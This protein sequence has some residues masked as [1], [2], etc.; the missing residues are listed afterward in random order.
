M[1]LPCEDYLNENLYKLL[2]V[3]KVIPDAS[4]NIYTFTM[5]LVVTGCPQPQTYTFNYGSF[6]EANQNREYIINNSFH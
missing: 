5:V 3:S 6:G 1:K 2:Y 4:K